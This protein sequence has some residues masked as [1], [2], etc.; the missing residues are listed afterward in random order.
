MTGPR[1]RH[2]ITY[3]WILKAKLLK[4]ENKMGVTRVWQVGEQDRCVLG[5][6]F[7]TSNI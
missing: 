7:R 4:I 6:K 2:T 5:F 3:M 1:E